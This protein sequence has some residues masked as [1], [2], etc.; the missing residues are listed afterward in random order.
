MYCSMCSY[1]EISHLW[2]NP[3]KFSPFMH[4]VEHITGVDCEFLSV[5]MHL[6]HLPKS[7]LWLKKVFKAALRYMC[8]HRTEDPS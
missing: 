7:F 6:E 5:G 8:L 3:I 2:M 4:G 1:H